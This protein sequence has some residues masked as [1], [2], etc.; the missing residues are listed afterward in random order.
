MPTVFD[1]LNQTVYAGLLV[2]IH[3]MKF[4]G[5]IGNIKSF[6]NLFGAKSLLRP[7]DDFELSFGEKVIVGINLNRFI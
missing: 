6:G 4:N 3:E 5:F 2:D 1:K 7:E